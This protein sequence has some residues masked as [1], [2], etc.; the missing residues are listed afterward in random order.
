[1]TKEAYNSL[2]KTLEEPP[3]YI[4]IIMIGSNEDNF[5]NTIK[6]RC[7]KIHFKKISDDILE[8]YLNNNYGYD[9]DK[10][11]IKAYEGSI[12]K[13]IKVNERKEEYEKVSKIFSNI[14]KYQFL[15][16]ITNLDF[17][18]KDKEI[19]YDILNYINI[20]LYSKLLQNPKYV[21]YIEAVEQT[22]KKLRANS[23]YDMS[24]DNMLY[25]IWEE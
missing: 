17:I 1:M 9:I 6:S 14:E 8:Q 10:N 18:Y 3:R 5:L 24:I 7:I 11:L 22:K 4:T 16:A 21:K 13:G 25:K 20:V 23:N 19:I 2:L 12:E 15:D